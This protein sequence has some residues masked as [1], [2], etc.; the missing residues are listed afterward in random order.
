MGLKCWKWKWLVNGDWFGGGVGV[1]V[2]V[3]CNEVG[4]G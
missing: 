2:D 4:T 1:K 3:R